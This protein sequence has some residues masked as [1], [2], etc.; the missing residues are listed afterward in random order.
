M[1]ECGVDWA[2]LISALKSFF[3]D[4]ARKVT[5]LF[6]GVLPGVV[7]RGATGVTC[8]EGVAGFLIGVVCLEAL[9]GVD[10]ALPTLFLVEALVLA[11]VKLGLPVSDATV[12]R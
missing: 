6:G 3:G 5:F 1:L 7:G 4:A 2:L 8:F 10:C 9:P 12:V 11:V